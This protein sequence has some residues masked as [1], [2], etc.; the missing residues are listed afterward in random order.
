MTDA[1]Q[2]LHQNLHE[3]FAERNP[4]RRRAAIERTYSEDVTFSR[5]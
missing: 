4:E 3:V 1:M 2:L 5:P